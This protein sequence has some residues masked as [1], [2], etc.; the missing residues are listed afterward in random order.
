MIRHGSDDALHLTT[1]NTMRDTFVRPTESAVDLDGSALLD[2]R[3]RI[4]GLIGS[5]SM[6]IV[7]LG[8]DVMLE[9]KVAIKALKPSLVGHDAAVERFS[10]E[11]RAMAAVRSEHVVRAHAFGRARSV[12]P[13]LVME[14]VDGVDLNTIVFQSERDPLSLTRAIAMLRE[15]ALGLAAVHHAGIVHRDVKPDNVLIERVTGRA[16]LADFGLARKLDATPGAR[17]LVSGTPF[18]MAP[19]QAPMSKVVDCATLTPRTD[20]YGLGCTAFYVLTREPMFV[21]FD[22]DALAE[23]HRSFP[24]PLISE[25]CPAAAFLDRVIAK[26]VEKNPEDRFADCKEFI[27]A[28]D[29]AVAAARL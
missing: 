24:P 22:C 15:L 13:F 4:D 29:R 7:H 25:K 19:E 26:A 20:V 8:Y 6:G 18:F 23:A 21:G 27:G 9:R 14:H 12:G 10:R 5:G 11:A 28:L 17:T 3:Y 16:V 1:R 2:G